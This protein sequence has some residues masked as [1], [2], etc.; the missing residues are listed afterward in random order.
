MRDFLFGQGYFVPLSN[1]FSLQELIGVLGARSASGAACTG[2]C[3]IHIHT[4]RF[5]IYIYRRMS[6]LGYKL[7]KRKGPASRSQSSR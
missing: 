7:G 2:S 6:S 1:A 5:Y 3:I 4:R